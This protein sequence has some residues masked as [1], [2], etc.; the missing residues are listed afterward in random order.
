MHDFVFSFPI[1]TR[2]KKIEQ[3]LQQKFCLAV[4]EM[5]KTFEVSIGSGKTWNGR[6]RDDLHREKWLTSLWKIHNKM[7]LAQRKVVHFFL[8]NSQQNVIYYCNITFHFDVTGSWDFIG[9]YSV[10]WTPSVKFCSCTQVNMH[11]VHLFT[12][13]E[14]INKLIAPIDSSYFLRHIQENKKL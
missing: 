6:D 11:V 3:D 7:S 13:H 8:K 9:S 2:H 1:K 14:D 4:P 12:S 5:L 10:G